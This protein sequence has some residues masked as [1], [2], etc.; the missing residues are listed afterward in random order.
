MEDNIMTHQEILHQA[1]QA[2]VTLVRFLYCGND[3]VSRAK[4]P[5]LITS[6][7]A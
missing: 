7:V 2:G 6:T 1:R 4:R 3:G 5:A